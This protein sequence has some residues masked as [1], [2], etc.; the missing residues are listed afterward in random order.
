MLNDL[1]ELQT[2]DEDV[3]GMPEISFT[4]QTRSE[5]GEEIVQRK[6]VFSRAP[7]WD[8]WLFNSFVEKRATDTPEVTSRSWR[9]SRRVF[10]DEAEEPTVDV[11]PEV[12]RKLENLLDADSVVLQK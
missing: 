8:K 10:W 7:E 5:E 2:S 4:I 6:Y 1:T 12:T 3:W 9:T 11:P